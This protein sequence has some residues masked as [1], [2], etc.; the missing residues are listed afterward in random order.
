MLILLQK[1]GKPTGPLTGVRPM[2][3]LSVRGKT[4][5]LIVL[6]RI[7]PKIGIYLSPLQSGFRRGHSTAD[8]MFGY[9]WLCAKAQRQR[10]TI[11]IMGF[12]LSHAFDVISR[13]KLHDTL[14]TFLDDSEL[15][16]IHHLLA[17][18]SPSNSASQ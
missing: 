1:P 15:R 2:A 16:M 4:L 6:S 10:V 17:D 8:I 13:D 14:D 5:S 11:E 9:R 18:A 7:A 12:D 3:S